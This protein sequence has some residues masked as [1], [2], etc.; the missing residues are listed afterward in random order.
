MLKKERKL[1]FTEL[2]LMLCTINTNTVVSIFMHIISL[3][4]M[5]LLAQVLSLCFIDEDTEAQGGWVTYPGPPSSHRSL[6]TLD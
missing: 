2:L 4:T 6:A 5:P 3:L 1:E